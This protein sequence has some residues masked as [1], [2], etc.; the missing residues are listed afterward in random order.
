MGNNATLVV[1]TDALHEIRED[2][3]FGQKVYDSILSF[4]SRGEQRIQSG[5]HHNAATVVGCHHADDIHVI[6]VGGNVGLNIGRL[7]TWRAEPKDLLRAWADS[8]G[9]RLVVKA[10]PKGER[11]F[12][13]KEEDG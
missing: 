13:P 1:L 5:M 10:K 12:A 7:G 3:D 9:Y 11:A 6:A 4:A 8:M 2:K